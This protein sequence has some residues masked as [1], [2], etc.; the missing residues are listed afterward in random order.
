MAGVSALHTLIF[1]QQFAAMIR[2]NLPLV[3]V[4][5]NLAEETPQRR[6]R[7]AIEDVS[8]DVVRGVDLGTALA[9]HPHIFDDVYVTVVR[10][11][12]ESG[13]LGGALL[14]IAQYQKVMHET[15]RKLKAALTYP[16][17]VVFAFF[18]IFNAMAFFI[19]P[20]FEQIYRNFHRTLPVPT[21]WLLNIKGYWTEYWYLIVGGAVALLVSFATWVSTADG[22]AVWDEM[23]LKLPIIGPLWRMS[24][25]ARFLR[26]LAV[27]VE[28]DV[29]VLEALRLAADSAGNVY[30]CELLYEIADDVE[31]GFGL[32]DSFRSH[33][34]FHGIVLQMIASGE[35]AG[36]LDELLTSSADYFDSL[37]QDRLDRITSLINPILTVVIG[38]AVAAMMIASFLPVF[39]LGSM[40]LQ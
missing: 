29:P 19:L 9:A 13:R 21:Q 27:Q 18:G 6:L 11:G 38:L 28:N 7:E 8:E 1:T 40:A 25:L 17:F 14:Q 26:T 23:K 35:E 10:A 36:I 2:S 39:E 24:A 20:R 33:R 12:L 3:D 34:I 22:R 37:V 31:R 5:A 32:A 4:M 30:V 15:G 16:L